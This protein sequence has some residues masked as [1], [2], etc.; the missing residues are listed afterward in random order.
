MRGIVVE[1][2]Q[3]PLAQDTGALSFL[4]NISAP[5]VA[6]VDS[7]TAVW[8]DHSP[9]GG[10]GWSARRAAWHGPVEMLIRHSVCGWRGVL[11]VRHRVCLWS[12]TRNSSPCLSTAPACPQ[13]PT[14]LEPPADNPAMVLWNT[15]TVSSARCRCKKKQ[16][17]VRRRLRIFT[18]P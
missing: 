10:V 3:A 15:A 13:R 8:Y 2:L 11:R 7:W 9:A 4:P 16:S 17:H 18:V 1:V 12:P 5:G 14:P 6:C